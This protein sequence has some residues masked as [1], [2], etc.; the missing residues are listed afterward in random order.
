MCH[1]LFQLEIKLNLY[2]DRAGISK[3]KF[4]AVWK[5]IFPT[6]DLKKS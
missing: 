6:V 2:M 4:M 1:L 3:A 5:S